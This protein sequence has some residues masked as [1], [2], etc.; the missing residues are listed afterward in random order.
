MFELR[1]DC[2]VMVLTFSCSSRSDA[3]DRADRILCKRNIA[4]VYLYK[5]AQC[6]GYYTCRSYDNLSIIGIRFIEA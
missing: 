1:I 3:Y 5:D 2:G 6:L 4:R